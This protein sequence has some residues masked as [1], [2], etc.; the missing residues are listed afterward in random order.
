MHPCPTCGAIATPGSAFCARCGRAFGGAAPGTQG[1]PPTSAVSGFDKT[2]PIPSLLGTGTPS[3]G[4]A[5]TGGADG[6]SARRP[7][8]LIGWGLGVFTVGAL[9]GGG[10]VATIA[11]A[12]SQRDVREASPSVAL[13]DSP[14]VARAP[15]VAE[16]RRAPEPA[17]AAPS[18]TP[19]SAAPITFGMPIV[20]HPHPAGDAVAATGQPDGRFVALRDRFITLQMPDGQ[21][22]VSDGTPAADIQ[23]VV[24]PARPGP[25]RVEIGVGH[26]VFVTVANS[27]RGSVEIDIDVEGVQ[28]RVG[29]FVRVSTRGLG[30]EVA[31]DA[32]LVRVPGAAGG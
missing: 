28:H 6:S 5:S 26:N 13:P 15:A 17:I 14:S 29:R 11:R 31:V 8:I 3:H 24:D 4:A 25:Y 2:V 1:L 27:A 7:S 16:Q 21:H 10:I 30:S 19:Q 20:H 12:G 9:V 22:L 18:P 23:V 32:V